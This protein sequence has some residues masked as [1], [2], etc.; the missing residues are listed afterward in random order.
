MFYS[1]VYSVIA[2]S[3]LDENVTRHT[4]T[5]DCY[6]VRSQRTISAVT[7]ETDNLFVA[8]DFV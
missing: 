2:L 1:Y 7:F 3:A 5:V 4:E 8:Y 6:Y